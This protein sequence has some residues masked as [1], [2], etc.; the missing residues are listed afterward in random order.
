MMVWL[1]DGQQRFTPVPLAQ[2]PT[3]LI[4]AAVGDLDGDGVPEIVTG[5]FHAYPPYKHM[6]RLTLWKRQ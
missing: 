5:G 6:S 3:H 1:N 4:T 2:A